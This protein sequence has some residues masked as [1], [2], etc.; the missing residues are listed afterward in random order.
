MSKSRSR[1]DREARTVQAMIRLYCR[2]QHRPYGRICPEC[3][4]L[5]RYALVRLR[6]CPYQEAKTTCARCSTHCYR[7]EMRERMRKVMRHSGP[8]M[9]Y[10]HPVLAI[11]HL[12]D[13]RRKPLSQA[14]TKPSPTES[15]PP[16]K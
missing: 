12:L 4:D 8:R 14:K 1:I 13:G 5:E 3:Q 15:T 11:L 7:P 10:R 9:I 16:D 2:E 6:R